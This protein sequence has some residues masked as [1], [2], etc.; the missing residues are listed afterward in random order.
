MNTY[1]VT[2][3]TMDNE[4]IQDGRQPDQTRER[5]LLAGLR[6]LA[7][8]GYRGATTR[9]I[10]QMAKVTEVTMYRHFR[11][12]EELL[13]AAVITFG[14][15]LVD[16]VPEPTGD[17]EADLLTLAVG[18]Q[19]HMSSIPM[20]LIQMVPELEAYPKSK[21][22]IN[23]LLQRFRARA[24]SLVRYYQ[25]RNVLVR[26]MDNVVLAALVGPLYF[27]SLNM[28]PSDSLA[29]QRFVRHFLGGYRSVQVPGQATTGETLS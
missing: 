27:W 25:E 3:T 29:C 15:G 7:A 12:K 21:E 1:R 13:A 18:F 4:E 23:D 28:E 19:E 17:V 9:E 24:L 26:D 2:K 20:K 6:L 16:V 10:A 11:S 5:L 22:A 8:K 14:E